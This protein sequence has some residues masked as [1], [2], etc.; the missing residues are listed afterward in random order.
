MAI[1]RYKNTPYYLD[2]FT[3]ARGMTTG[4][5]EIKGFINA[6]LDCDTLEAVADVFTAWAGKLAA[7]GAEKGRGTWRYFLER[8]AAEYRRGKIPGDVFKRETANYRSSHSQHSRTLP[9]PVPGM[10][11][12]L[13]QFQGLSVSC[14]Y[15]PPVGKHTA[16]AIR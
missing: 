11:V 16:P 7:R 9:A 6:V 14:R 2:A 1:T 3:P 10:L 12:V 15:A 8:Q 13:L 5:P 4:F